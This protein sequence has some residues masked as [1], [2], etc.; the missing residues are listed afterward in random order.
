MLLWKCFRSLHSATVRTIDELGGGAHVHALVYTYVALLIVASI[1]ALEDRLTSSVRSHNKEATH[2][3]KRTNERTELYFIGC[4][5]FQS[6]RGSEVRECS[7]KKMKLVLCLATVIAAAFALPVADKPNAYHRPAPP[8]YSPHVAPQ[9][10]A[11]PLCAY[12]PYCDQAPHGLYHLQ[13]YYSISSFY[14]VSC[15]NNKFFPSQSEIDALRLRNE[16]I[17]KAGEKLAQQQPN[18]PFVGGYQRYY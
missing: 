11:V 9:Y 12:Y 16:L 1:S 8:A 15:N 13:V 4:L 18:V 6:I 5:S 7:R 14:I 17:V 2:S 10:E 3:N